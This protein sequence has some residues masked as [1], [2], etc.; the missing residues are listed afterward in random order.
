M[1]RP[2]YGRE[3][4]PKEVE[5]LHWLAHGL[6]EKAIGRRLRISYL[7]VNTHTKH[8]KKK[9]RKRSHEGLLMFWLHRYKKRRLPALKHFR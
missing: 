9:T 4:S 7:T 1:A 2:S 6:T 3:L 8:I 5:V